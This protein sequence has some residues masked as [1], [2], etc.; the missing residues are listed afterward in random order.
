MIP[1]VVIDQVRDA[2]DIVEIVSRFTPLKR[3]GSAYKALCPM[4]GHDE[5]TPSFTVNPG[6]QIYKCFGCGRGGNVFRFLMEMQ[7]L[8]FVEAVRAL[9][10]ERG[11]SLPST[12]GIKGPPPNRKRK[13]LRALSLAQR[14]FH[15]CLLRDGEGD[16][17]RAYLTKRGYDLSAIRQFGLGYAPASRHGLIDALRKRSVDEQTLSDAGLIYARE[18]AKPA[19]DRFVHRVMF[20]VTNL[21]GQVVTFGGR[22][23]NPEERAKYLNGPE[24]FVFHK[25]QTLYALDRAQGPIRKRGE[26]LIMEG[27][28][29]VLMCHMHGFDHAVAG[30]GTAFTAQQARLI[31]RFASRALLLYDA[32]DAGQ[33][34][35]ERAV[36]ILLE[37]GLEVRVVVLPEGRDVD[38]ILLEDGSDA[39]DRIL[40]GALN[41]FDYKIVR[42]GREHDL[43]TPRGRAAVVEALAPTIVRVRSPVEREQLIRHVAERI[44]GDREQVTT[45]RLLRAEAA[46]VVQSEQRIARRRSRRSAPRAARSSANDATQVLSDEERTRRE[47]RSRDELDLLGGCFVSRELL[48]AVA[49]AMGPEDF[50][51]LAHRR[52]YEGVL[53][54]LD[55][56]RVESGQPMELHRLLKRFMGDPEVLNV[57]TALPDDAAL[58]E[59]VTFQIEFVEK[60]RLR[61]NR[62]ARLKARLREGAEA[63]AN[64][65]QT[66]PASSVT[67]AMT[68]ASG[69]GSDPTMRLESPLESPQKTTEISKRVVANDAQPSA[70][71]D[72]LDTVQLDIQVEFDEEGCPVLDGPPDDAEAY[73]AGVGDEQ[74]ITQEASSTSSRSSSGSGTLTS[75]TSASNTST[76]DDVSLVVDA[77]ARSSSSSD[78]SSDAN[79]SN[80]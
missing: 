19:A 61:K 28:T 16:V 42:L 67:N 71:C 9:A 8:T 72:P 37:A 44:G 50:V 21:Q 48:D 75:G 13:T 54:E 26:A 15:A 57:L 35:A 53:A 30:M 64:P 52:A 31:N 39:L 63:P 69:E 6:R 58:D 34:A 32:D 79:E 4:Q 23:L 49:R 17:A 11:I 55:A 62:F 70:G 7:G 22:A 73:I 27:Y 59:R 12:S 5:K 76:S 45:E 10:E 68:G 36:E 38:E 1:D 43:R 41:L 25:S 77:D 40:G 74:W 80:E 65:P 46:R 3:M 20:P 60:D 14:Y 56:G 2:H 78:P 29:D 33:K 18:G 66:L 24:T 51:H 47:S